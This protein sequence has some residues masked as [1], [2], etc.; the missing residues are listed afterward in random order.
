MYNADYKFLDVFSMLPS[1]LMSCFCYFLK[2]KYKGC[3][4]TFNVY[5]F[6]RRCATWSCSTEPCTGFSSGTSIRAPTGSQ[7]TG[8]KT[9]RKKL[10]T[11]N[12]Q[13]RPEAYPE[14]AFEPEAR[15]FRACTESKTSGRSMLTGSKTIGTSLQS[16][17]PKV[18]K[19]LCFLFSTATLKT[20][21]NQL[22]FTCLPTCIACEILW[23]G[24]ECTFWKIKRI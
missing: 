7:L 5:C 13:A 8:S 18:D 2:W 19:L 3:Y 9:N 23:I 21:K 16:G 6:F 12:D 15:L 24:S 20:F 1:N 17:N 4:D 14:R 10:S 22:M 11:V